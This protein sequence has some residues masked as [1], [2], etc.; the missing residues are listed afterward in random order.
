MALE[1]GA[2]SRQLSAEI[3]SLMKVNPSPEYIR[4]HLSEGS[5]KR[6]AA[7][8]QERRIS[9]TLDV[10]RFL[11]ESG[12]DYAVLKGISL[13]FYDRGR[14]FADLDILVRQEDAK[15]AAR[16]LIGKYGYSFMRPKEVGQL[17][18]GHVLNAHDLTLVSKKTIPVEIHYKL[19]NYLPT[20]HLPL[21]SGKVFLE[22]DG[23]RIP[24]QK[25]EYQMLELALHNAYHHVFMCDWGKW[26]RDINL[27]A[28]NRKVDWD[29]FVRLVTSLGQRE[30]V[31]LVFSTLDL[32]GK[33]RLRVPPHVFA[34]LKPA[35]PLAY[36]KPGV[37]AWA[38]RFAFDR[39][40][41]PRDQLSQ[42]TGI[43]EDSPL[44]VFAYPLNWLRIILE[45][46][47]GT[48]KA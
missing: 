34:R 31:C 28:D 18:E 41:P 13:S 22:M 5:K 20:E 26:A 37:W 16:L 15:K 11:N 4:A 35:T 39:L 21:L 27:L 46:L 40:F 38:L 43:R 14:E 36:L 8:M 24:C 19:F 2:G 29:S 33:P 1:D 23:V 30:L 17:D 47:S 44:L 25:L 10:I 3:A 7:L 32:A 45:T 9:Q 42:K 48:A 6:F 12:V